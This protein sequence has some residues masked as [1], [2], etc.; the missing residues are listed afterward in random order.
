MPYQLNS[1]EGNA[2]HYLA[3]ALRPD[4]AHNK[5]G[6]VWRQQLREDT[7]DQAENFTHAVQALIAYTAPEARMRT[8]NLY[9]QPG[10]HWDK[11]APARVRDASPRC[12]DH[13]WEPAS[14]CRACHADVKVGD[15]PR[16]MIGKHLPAK[17]TPSETQGTHE[18]AQNQAQEPRTDQK[19]LDTHPPF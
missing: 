19:R 12:V 11:T 1:A 9:P 3:L 2:L 17:T 14:T 15:R 7:F 16:D 6:Q 13:N 8:P 5:P 10:A 4:W 18:D